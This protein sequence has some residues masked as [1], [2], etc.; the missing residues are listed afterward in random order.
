MLAGN[1]R[2]MNGSEELRQRLGRIE[3]RQPPCS[4]PHEVY[5]ILR[6]VALGA[7]AMRRV[8]QLASLPL[9]GTRHDP[10]SLLSAGNGVTNRDLAPYP[11]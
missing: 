1:D 10:V 7:R 5:Q 9:T 2:W 6:D 8:G 4:P 11:N 3:R